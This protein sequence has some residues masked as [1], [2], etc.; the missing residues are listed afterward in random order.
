MFLLLIASLFLIMM[1]LGLL[2]HH[3]S[4]NDNRFS[5]SIVIACRDEEKNLSDLFKALNRLDYFEGL[6]EI[7][8]VDDNSKDNSLLL[9]K[10]YASKHKHVKVISLKEMNLFGKREALNQGISNAVNDVI[11]LTDADCQPPS[12]WISTTSKYISEDTAM[13]VGYS[14][15][16][17]NSGFRRFTQLMSAGIYCSTIGLGMPF[18]CSGRNLAFMKETFNNLGGYSG[19]EKYQSGDDKLLLNRFRKANEIITYNP[20]CKVFTKESLDKKNQAKRRYGKFRMSNML[21]QI[22]QL[23]IFGFYLSLPFFLFFKS[24]HVMLIF[25]YISFL[26]FWFCNIYRHK[27]KFILSDLIY[28]LYYPYYLI[29]HSIMGNVTNWKWKND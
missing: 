14:P 21:F 1:G 9:L 20:E 10:K 4:D 19:F 18:S 13:V 24:Y 22:L 2:K 11:L 15:E 26:F 3:I 7:V 25:Y 27:A 29:Y 12:D 6:W 23:L 17:T 28:I 8:L 5:F 16:I